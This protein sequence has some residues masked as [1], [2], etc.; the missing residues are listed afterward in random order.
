[1]L[2]YILVGGYLP[3]IEGTSSINLTM[4]VIVSH[5]YTFHKERGE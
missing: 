4:C 2:K 3:L 5:V 1:M